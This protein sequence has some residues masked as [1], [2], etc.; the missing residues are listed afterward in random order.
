MPG[1]F[2]VCGMGHNGYRIVQLLLRLGDPVTIVTLE[3]RDEWRRYVEAHGA[4]VLVGDARDTEVLVDAGLDSAV[5]LI[6][7]TDNDLVNLEIALDV[8]QRRPGLASVIRIFD[9]TLARQLEAAFDVRRALSMSAIAAPMFAAAAMGESGVCAFRL[10]DQFF[11]VQSEPVSNGSPLLERTLADI[12][13]DL[14]VAAIYHQ[15]GK[16][17]SGDRA[18]AKLEVGDTALTLGPLTEWRISSLRSNPN[19]SVKVS[20]RH[21]HIVE[22]FLNCLRPAFW[23]DGIRQLWLGASLPLRTIFL[24][25]NIVILLSVGVFHYAMH[26]SLIDAFYFV[27]TTVTT[28]G[29]GDITPRHDSTALKLYTCLLMLLGSATIATLFSI[30]T[31]FIVTARFRQ[32]LGRQ[33]VPQHDHFIVVGLGTV[34]FRLVQKLHSAGARVVAVD[35]DESSEFVESARAIVP[36]VIGDARL[37]ETLLKVGVTRARAVLAVTSNDAVN[38]GVALEAK[39]IAPNVRT[40]ARLF[41]P[42]FAAKVK[43]Q[44]GV[45]AAMGAFFVSAPTFVAA[46]LYRDV[47]HAFVLDNVL[48]SILHCRVRPEWNGKTPQEIVREFGID[49]AMSRS[50]TNHDFAVAPPGRALAATDWA[51]A[52]I[53]RELSAGD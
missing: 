38:L 47:L 44:L 51:L 53:R 17:G 22:P 24:A 50:Q 39:Q 26:L 32:L 27:V 48:F 12:R 52:V 42:D 10:N 34:G 20:L 6:A 21:S 31:D 16:P 43:S 18:S 29:Y 35:R 40:V 7:A 36:V 45:D 1:H 3:L 4:R 28:V 9:Q 46:S 37:K 2:I 19:G 15:P 8:K 30:I 33:R 14:G 49:I 41:E 5:A 25:L 11:V 23:I 13:S